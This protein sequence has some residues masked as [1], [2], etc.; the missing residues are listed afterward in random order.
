MQARN[1]TLGEFETAPNQNTRDIPESVDL[2]DKSSRSDDMA[3]VLTEWIEGLQE[4]T[5]EAR[6]A[7]AFRRWLDAQAQF[8]DYSARNT[9]L[10]QMQKPDASKVAGFWTW[11]NE[12]DRHVK[13]GEDAIW[14]WRPNTFTGKKCPHCGNKPVY[15]EGNEDLDCPLA[16]EGPDEWDDEDPE[17]WAEGEILG[18][19]S[20]APVFDISQTEGEPLPESPD[21]DAEAGAPDQ[22]EQV[23]SSL[24]DASREL[25]VQLSVVDVDEWDRDAKAIA[26]TSQDPPEIEI[27]DREPAAAAGDLAHELAHAVLHTGWDTPD[28]SAREIEAEAVAYVVGRYF[29]LDTSNSKFYLAA[30]AGDDTEEIA[31]RMKTISSTAE[32]IIEAASTE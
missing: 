9:F 11:Q 1:S 7:E 24:Q 13:E 2:S 8:H 30:W 26:R 23:L 18:G 12:F 5:E 14:I 6:E 28:R 15:H 25:G 29:G 10:I 27:Q 16:P 22:G 31:A 17:G 4:A 3:D 32:T 19:F 21:T 20:P